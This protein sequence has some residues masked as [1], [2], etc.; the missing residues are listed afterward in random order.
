MVKSVTMVMSNEML[1]MGHSCLKLSRMKK[2]MNKINS[3]MTILLTLSK[4]RGEFRTQ[5]NIK[6]GAI[7]KNNQWF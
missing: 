5:S 3:E 1:F 4:L 2:E 7:C 6:S